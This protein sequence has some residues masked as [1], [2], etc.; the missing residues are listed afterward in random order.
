MAIYQYGDWILYHDAMFHEYRNGYMHVSKDCSPWFNLPLVLCVGNN[1]CIF[2]TIIIVCFSDSQA[3]GDLLMHTSGSDEHQEHGL[4][5][6]KEMHYTA[7]V[8][9]E[10]FT[11]FWCVFSNACYVQTL[12]QDFLNFCIW[13]TLS[14]VDIGYESG[15]NDLKATGDVA[16]FT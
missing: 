16:T 11:F 10:W 2:W 4:E 14:L 6:W 7:V 5:Y 12:P 1:V 15:G 8:C 9:T 3:L 13:N